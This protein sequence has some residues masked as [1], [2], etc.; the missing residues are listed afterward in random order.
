M[1]NDS[2]GFYW[3]SDKYDSQTAYA[4]NMSYVSENY[5]EEKCYG[6]SIRPVYEASTKEFIYDMHNGKIK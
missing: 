1:Y 4:I 3:T 5:T 6:F 2:R